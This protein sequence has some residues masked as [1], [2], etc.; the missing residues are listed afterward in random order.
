M[1]RIERQEKIG[2]RMQRPYVI[3]LSY[4]ERERLI[5]VVASV[6]AFTE[7]KPLFM[8]SP[9]T[10]YKLSD[11]KKCGGGILWLNYKSK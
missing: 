11:V 2:V 5:D 9:I 6:V 8:G 10:D 4:A 1:P 3:Y 7:D